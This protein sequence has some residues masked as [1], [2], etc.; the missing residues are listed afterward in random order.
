[1][2]RIFA[3]ALAI[4]L[5]AGSYLLVAS[6]S[7]ADYPYRKPGLWEVTSQSSSTTEFDKI[8]K[9]GK[10][11]AGTK[12]CIDRD[13]DRLF[14]QAGHAVSKQL[15]PKTDMKVHG[16]TVIVETECR[17]EGLSATGRTVTAIQETSYHSESDVHI[18][19]QPNPTHV[20]QDGRSNRATPS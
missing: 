8:G 19:G 17:G 15:C 7:G 16:T 4:G 6:L 2:R 1:M 14:L 20:S 5:A 9:I 3:A 18:D 11:V 13:T 12:F 10:L